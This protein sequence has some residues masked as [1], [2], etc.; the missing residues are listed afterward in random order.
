M[1]DFGYNQSEGTL[2]TTVETFDADYGS[3]VW[4]INGADDTFAYTHASGA[5]R[6][7]G[8]G[9]TVAYVGSL[10]SD[11]FFKLGYA[12]DESGSAALADGGSVTSPS[13]SQPTEAQTLHIGSTANSGA[14]LNG[15]IKSIKYYPRRLTNAQ[16]QEITS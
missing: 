5:W 9:G 3:Y 16:L 12:F 1:A 14:Q 7:A 10:P 4:T 6:I 13:H 11:D 8:A 15:H 2:I